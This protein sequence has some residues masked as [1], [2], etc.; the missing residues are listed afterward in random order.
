MPGL[1]LIQIFKSAYFLFFLLPTLF[2][3]KNKHA[4]NKNKKRDAPNI[5]LIHKYLFF[6]YRNKILYFCLYLEK[7]FVLNV[8]NKETIIGKI[9]N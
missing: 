2:L 1:C 5:F 8:E 7:Q 6:K 4:N 3:E 9:P